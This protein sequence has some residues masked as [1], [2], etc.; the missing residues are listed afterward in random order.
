MHILLPQ[1]LPLVAA[2]SCV[3]IHSGGLLL[4]FTPVDTWSAAR[5]IKQLIKF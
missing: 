2:A 1:S 4:P 3:R 5:V